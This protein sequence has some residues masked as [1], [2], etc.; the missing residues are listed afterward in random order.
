[1]GNFWLF[2]LRSVEH[3][4]RSRFA[5][6]GNCGRADV[7][8][9]NLRSLKL[10]SL[11][12]GHIVAKAP[13]RYITGNRTGSA[14]RSGRYR[15]N[16][17]PIQ[18]SAIPGSDTTEGT[19]NES[20]AAIEAHVGAAFHNGITDI[21]VGA[22]SGSET[23]GKAICGSTGSGSSGIS[24]PAEDTARTANTA[25][26]PGDDSGGHHQFHAHAGS[27]LRHIQADGGQIAVESL[28]ALQISQ[29]AEHPQKDASF[30]G[31]QC[32]AVCNELPHGGRKT[33]KKPDVHDKEQQ[34]GTNHPAPGLGHGVRGF[35]AAHRKG[36]RRGIAQNTNNDVPFYG[37]QQELEVV[38]SQRNLQN[39][40]QDQTYNG[41]S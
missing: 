29:C 9:C 7:T 39:E 21:G 20:G 25:A 18:G 38:P 26:C 1:M 2:K 11:H 17:V 40:D 13:V 24:A 15:G 36:E 41:C 16:G 31:G 14:G 28:G 33:T 23:G 5:I 32:T 35:G 37:F 3:I 8:A 34:L 6:R 10:E 4:H 27:G 30:T 22:E 19:A 12:L